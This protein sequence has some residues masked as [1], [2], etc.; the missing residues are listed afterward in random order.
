MFAAWKLMVGASVVR[1][2]LTCFVVGVF[3]VLMPLC[4]PGPRDV[5]SVS[6]GAATADPYCLA[7]RKLNQHFMI[8][9]GSA[10]RRNKPCWYRQD[11]A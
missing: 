2:I 6:L 9:D 10:T 3:Q 4:M 8:M 11:G 7:S 1:P 5:T